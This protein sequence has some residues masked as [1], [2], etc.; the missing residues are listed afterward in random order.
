VVASVGRESKRAWTEVIMYARVVRSHGKRQEKG[1]S[2]LL[3][4]GCSTET[5]CSKRWVVQLL[6][7]L[8]TPGI[9]E[10]EKTS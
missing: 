6:S 9:E 2:K 4:T 10:A 3:S 8:V 1:S 5:S 7:V